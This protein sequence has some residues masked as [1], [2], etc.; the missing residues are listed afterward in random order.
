MNGGMVV[1]WLVILR[2]CRIGEMHV[3]DILKQL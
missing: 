3:Y 1:T 2:L